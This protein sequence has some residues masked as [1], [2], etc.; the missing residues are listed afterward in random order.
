[1]K[2]LLLVLLG[3]IVVFI[4]VQKAGL[5]NYFSNNNQPVV[6]EQ[7]TIAPT[8]DISPVISRFLLGIRYRMIDKQ[9]ADQNNLVEGAYI[10]QIIKESPAE[11]ADLQEEDIITE[12]DGNK[13]TLFETAQ[14]GNVCICVCDFPA[15]AVLGPFAEGEYEFKVIDPDGNSLGTVPVVIE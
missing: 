14:T 1:M 9:T 13:I 8:G 3:L 15:I 6:K 4:I 10:T 12:V 11:K 5:L 7:L 2:K